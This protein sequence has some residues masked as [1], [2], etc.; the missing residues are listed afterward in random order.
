MV[1]KTTAYMA[2]GRERKYRGRSSLAFA[3]VAAILCWSCGTV[4]SV[5][6][7][8]GTPS[9]TGSDVTIPYTLLEHG[10]HLS[11]GYTDIIEVSVTVRIRAKNTIDGSIAVYESR[12][13]DE[14][15]S[16]NSTTGYTVITIGSNETYVV[17]SA[18]VIKIDADDGSY[19]F[20]RSRER[21]R[22]IGAAP[23][24]MAIPRIS[25]VVF[26]RPA[27]LRA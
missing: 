20:P 6:C 11:S 18:E 24:P 16:G 7:S 22:G 14:I 13:Y 1:G 26:N 12:F 15:K 5:T 17:G 19:F 23:T 8:L 3:A 10:D 27:S 9:I 25:H 21:P 4:K 2:G